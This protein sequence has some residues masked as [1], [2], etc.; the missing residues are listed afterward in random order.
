[1]KREVSAE[2]VGQLAG[3][4][5]NVRYAAAIDAKSIDVMRSELSSRGPRYTV[6]AA[7]PL[8]DS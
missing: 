3:L 1:V 4:A 2:Q 7:V 5:A 8:G 6:L